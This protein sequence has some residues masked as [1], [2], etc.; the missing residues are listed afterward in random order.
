MNFA[1]VPT[2]APTI[3][4]QRMLSI[5]SP[6]EMIEYKKLTLYWQFMQRLAFANLH[7]NICALFRG[8]IENGKSEYHD[9]SFAGPC[10]C[11]GLAKPR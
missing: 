4:V 2:I 10:R 5:V 9:K 1:T 3:T 6:E 11:G 8:V 7:T